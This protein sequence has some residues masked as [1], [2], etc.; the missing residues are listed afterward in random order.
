MENA[1][2]PD[3][4]DQHRTPTISG[5]LVS[6][7]SDVSSGTTRQTDVYVHRLS[8]SET[9]RV[10]PDSPGSDYQ[11]QV[12]GNEVVYRDTSSLGGPPDDIYVATDY[13]MRQT[14]EN[15]VVYQRLRDGALEGAPIQITDNGGT[16]EF[17]DVS[18][19]YIVYASYPSRFNT[20]DGSHTDRSSGSIV[21]HQI[22]TGTTREIGPADEFARPKIEGTIVAWKAPDGILAYR[23]VTQPQVGP[24]ALAGPTPSVNSFE[25][26]DRFIVWGE[27]DW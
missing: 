19:D 4:A 22:S 27:H 13:A 7:E 6:W 26:G 2:L 5:D 17:P 9:F 10:T 14:D 16:N 11:P 3:G 15:H 18:G 1:N 23:D 24:R 25:V 21:A 20:L 12:F 8:T